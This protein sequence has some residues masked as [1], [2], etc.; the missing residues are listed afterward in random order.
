MKKQEKTVLLQH[1]QLYKEKTLH[2]KECGV[3]WKDKK[4]RPYILPEGEKTQ[5]IIATYREELLGLF[6]CKKMHRGFAHLNS[7]QALALNLFGPLVVE[8]CL[9]KMESLFGASLLDGTGSFEVDSKL[10]DGTELDFVVEKQ[11]KL[12]LS[13]EVKYTEACFAPGT[14]NGGHQE[15]YKET[16][17]KELEKRVKGTVPSVEIFLKDYQIWRNIVCG[18]DVVAFVFPRFRADMVERVEAVKATLQK[19]YAEK[20]K[21][22]YIDDIVDEVLKAYPSGCKLADHYTE[23]KEKYLPFDSVRN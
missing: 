4:A 16:Y 21:C 5:N 19:R 14:N 3:W 9:C 17:Q 1:L 22:V 8:N 18:A 10:G 6:P 7:S 2:V 12:V 15:K 13:V 20:V 11:G 23:F